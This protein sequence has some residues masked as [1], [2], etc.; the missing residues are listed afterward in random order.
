MRMM[1][2]KKK[3]QTRGQEDEFWMMASAFGRTRLET[4]LT[5]SRLVQ[6]KGDRLCSSCVAAMRMMV[7]EKKNR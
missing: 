4:V 1:V 3:E 7:G 2:G 6:W 5:R